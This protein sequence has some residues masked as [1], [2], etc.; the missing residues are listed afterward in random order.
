M[1]RALG[2]EGR[3]SDDVAEEDGDAVER[4]R[5]R[6]LTTFHLTQNLTRK[7]IGQQLF[8]LLLLLAVGLHS[9]VV[10]RREPSRENENER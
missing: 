8:R 10:H 3:K 7:Q 4:L 1:R 2:R 6:H 9:L 5:L